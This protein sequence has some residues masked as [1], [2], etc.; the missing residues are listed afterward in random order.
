[1]AQFTERAIMDTFV[2][3]LEKMP[4][5]KIKVRDITAAC[6]ISRNTFY[7]HFANVY[8]LLEAVLRRDME[9]ILGA[10]REKGESWFDGLR[11]LFTY[12]SDNR[13]MIYHIYISGSQPTLERPFFQLTEEFFMEYIREA[14]QGLAVSLEDLQFICFSYQ[15]MLVGILMEWL[16]QGM[17]TDLNQLLDRAQRLLLGNTRRILEASVRSDPPECPS[18]SAC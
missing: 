6:G 3:L 17:K 7:Y 9:R 16:R 4:L 11:R 12:S 5:D 14:A 1:M 2:R 8:A 10:H 18:P 15:A 13:R